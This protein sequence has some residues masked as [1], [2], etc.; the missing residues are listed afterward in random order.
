M[1]KAIDDTRAKKGP[2]QCLIE[3]VEVQ[4]ERE[5]ACTHIV[6]DGLNCNIFLLMECILHTPLVCELWSDYERRVD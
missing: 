1:E 4:R 3:C 6:Y 2:P 5:G